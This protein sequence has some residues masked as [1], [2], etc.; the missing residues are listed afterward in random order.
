MK[1]VVP[2]ADW[3]VAQQSNIERL[4]SDV[5]SHITRW[6]RV[7]FTDTVCVIPGP[8]T[9][10]PMTYYRGNREQ[11]FVVQLTARDR[12]WS[13][14]A[15]QFSHEFCHILSE[16]ERFRNN[17]NQWFHESIC[18]LASAFTLRQMATYWLICPPYPNWVGYATSLDEYANELV[19]RKEHQLPT[20]MTLST[21]LASVE[22]GLR[23]DPYQRDKNGVVAY[24][25]LHVFESE[26]TGWNAIRNLPD[27]SA[28]LKD[29]LH[30][31]RLQVDP[32]DKPFVTRIIQ[33]FEE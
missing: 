7:T 4:L 31:W 17:P 21:W 33:L 15:Y 22:D 30:N 12:K 19:S 20:G 26:P 8:D 32:I 24:S 10:V 5:A 3:G 29:Y 28:M 1:I 16:Y 25:L 14:F 23:E 9:S 13:K 11:P 18:E 2:Q 27:S 6:L